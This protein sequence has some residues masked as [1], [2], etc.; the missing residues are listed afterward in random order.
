[1]CRKKGALEL[2]LAGRSQA[3]RLHL[4]RNVACHASPCRRYCNAGQR[5]VLSASSFPVFAFWLLLWVGHGRIPA[6]DSI[7]ASNEMRGLP[8]QHIT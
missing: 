8:A 5:L 6:D 2:G 7:K 3:P 1:M 4:R